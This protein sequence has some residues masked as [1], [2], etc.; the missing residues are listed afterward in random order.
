MRVNVAPW[1]VDMYMPDPRLAT[2]MRSALAD[3]SAEIQT[4]PWT[5]VA[6]LETAASVQ[7]APASVETCT[8]P[9]MSRATSVSPVVLVDTQCHVD[10]ARR[11]VNVVPAATLPLRLAVRISWRAFWVTVH[12]VAVRPVIAIVSPAA[13]AAGSVRAIGPAPVALTW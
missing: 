1:S 7:V 10:G 13:A 6:P 8:S 2:T 3:M 9:G 4:L 12:G 11:G 5:A